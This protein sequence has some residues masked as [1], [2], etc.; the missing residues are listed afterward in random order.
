MTGGNHD[1][2]NL[3]NTS[4]PRYTIGT[5]VNDPK[6][7]EQMLASYHSHGFTSDDCEF[8]SIDTTRD[9]VACAYRGLNL[10]LNQAR[11]TYVILCHQDIRLLDD[12]RATLDKRLDE[13][14]ALDDSWAIAGNAGGV[15]PGRLAIRITDP[16]GADQYSV[17]LP[18]KVASLD[19]NFLIIRRNAR[20]GFSRNLTG[21]HFYGADICLVA[22]IVGA[23][24]YVIDFHLHHLSA[25]EKD[26]KYNAMKT[27]FTRKWANALRPR[28]LQTTCNLFY[29]T[30][31]TTGRIFGSMAEPLYS[32]ASRHM[33]SARGWYGDHTANQRLD[34]DRARDDSGTDNGDK[35][36][37]IKNI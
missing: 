31:Q 7:Y 24:C 36:A 35:Y 25:G 33:P 6:Q 37:S 27:A 4:I 26:A 34:P 10:L 23:S 5:L 30:G 28:W 9:N 17:D 18:A 29:L 12:D 22:D 20:I 2:L 11:G 16:H 19:E 14:S 8:F 15:S 32:R 13:L 1:H 3:D 21:F